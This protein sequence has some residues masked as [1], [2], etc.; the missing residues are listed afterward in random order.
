MTEEEF[1][2]YFHIVGDPQFCSA[3]HYNQKVEKSVPLKDI[4]SYW[5]WRDWNGVTP[6]K[7]QRSCG[8][9]WTFS[10]VGALEAHYLIKYGEFRNIS[11]QQLVDCA[12]AFDNHGCS[13]GLP[14]HAFEYIFYAGGI[15]TETDYVYTA[16]DGSCYF[17]KNMASIAVNGGSVNIT[18]GDESELLHAVFEH[19]PVSVCYQVVTGFRDY[20]SG[21]YSSSTCKNSA[22]DVNH[23]VL[24]VGFGQDEKGMDYW[25]VKNSWGDT[26]GDKGYFKIQRG[27]NM[28]GMANCNSY[29][30]DVVPVKKDAEEFTQ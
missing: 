18:L 26:W 14:S 13:G 1:N 23:A 7:N 5:D 21:V 29:P 6:V 28:C 10:T 12:G 30:K 24:A 20:K 22:M 8:S 2:D 27:V 25:I 19:G 15:A 16:K 3:T 11:E 9:C 4:P 17:K